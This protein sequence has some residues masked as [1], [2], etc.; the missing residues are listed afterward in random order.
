MENDLWSATASL[1][2]HAALLRKLAQDTN[3]VEENSGGRTLLEEAQMKRKIASEIRDLLERMH[4][5]N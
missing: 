2:E 4:S 5:G 3:T 1:Q